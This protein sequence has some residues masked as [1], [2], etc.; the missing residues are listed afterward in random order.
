MTS[1]TECEFKFEGE[2][3]SIDMNT[4]IVSQYNYYALLTHIKDK[5]FPDIKFNIKIKTFEKGSFDINQVVEFVAASGHLFIQNQDYINSIFA[6]ICTYIELKKVLK[7]KKPTHIEYLSNNK[8][9]ITLSG[10]NNKFQC[11]KQ[12]FEA[13]QDDV[14]IHKYI[15][16][17]FT[18]LE[19]D[20]EV[21]GIA[22]NNLTNEEKILGV[23][24]N[25]FHALTTENPYF[26]TQ[27]KEKIIDDAILN[28]K[29][30]DVTPNE[31]TKWDFLF[32][33]RIIK[34]VTI[35]DELFLKEVSAGRKFG[36]GDKLRAKLKIIYKYNNKFT[37]FTEYKFE[38]LEVKEI[39]L[40]PEQ[41]AL[42]E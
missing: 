34:S 25:A 29:K 9:E 17:F 14:N 2:I 19:N 30:L 23:K 12:I 28:I 10:D 13:F 39:L 20:D 26:D 1:K 36:N 27:T 24:R 41:K 18:T 22:I 40:T 3:D 37:A 7:D 35:L 11:D 32:E 21:T 16:K 33:G 4:L 5:L 31:S 15:T 42:F 38:I 6:F 8:V